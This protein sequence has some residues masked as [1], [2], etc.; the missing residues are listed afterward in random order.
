MKV[1]DYMD[2]NKKDKLKEI[3]ES[4][5]KNKIKKDKKIKDGKLKKIFAKRNKTE[6]SIAI[7]KDKKNIKGSFLEKLRKIVSKIWIFEVEGRDDYSFKEVVV[8]MLFSLGLGFFTCFSFVMI[9]NNGRDY[10]TLTKDFDKLVDTYYAIK[11]NY[12]G[13]LDTDMLVDSAIEGMVGA[14][15]DVYTSYSDAEATDSFMQTVSGVYE[16]IGCTVATS[17]DGRIIIVDMFKDSPSE[18]A[19]LKVGD[20]IIK[21]D[22]E[23]YSEKSSTDMSNYVKNSK[24]SEVKLVVIREEEEIE[25][26]VKREKIE[27]PYVTSEIIEKNDKKVGYI[28]ISL[29]SSVT[30]NQ[31]KS[32]LEKLE[33]DGI[34][35]LIIDVRGNSGGYL[36][37]VTDIIDMFLKKGD[38]IYRLEDSSGTV[39]KKDTTK[40]SRKYPVAVLVNGGSASASEILAAAIKESYGG[41][42]VGTNTFGKGTVQQTT[43]LPDGSMVK[44]TIQNWL[45]PDGNWINEV[46]LEPTNV[47]E[48][49]ENY[50]NEPIRDNDNQLQEALNLVTK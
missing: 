48:L 27:I 13:E 10:K 2:I 17:L 5:K 4:K 20:I 28:N 26:I 40:E 15:G 7:K 3:K 39:S 36:S 12:Y 44:Y 23:D 6:K 18:K 14:V 11:D 50:M 38:V 19:G 33:K 47:V 34:D 42:V 35:S 46:G 30:N 24:N 41:F 31:F 45:T 9:F 8:I 43:T 29:F 37:S 16:G 22:G 25:I 32:E 49:D 21:I 1:C